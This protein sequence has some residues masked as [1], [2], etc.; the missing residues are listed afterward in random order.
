MSA[1]PEKTSIPDNAAPIAPVLKG[2]VALVTGASSGIGAG[3]AG[4]MAAAGA[5][6]ILVGRDPARLERILSKVSD[7]SSSC[8]AI[9]ADLSHPDG[10]ATVIDQAVALAGRI[11]CLVNNAGLFVYEPFRE[12]PEDQL[13]AQYLVNV[14]APYALTRA[15]VPVMPAGSS[16]VFVSSNLARVGMAG[17]AA[18]SATKG[19]VESM[20]RALAVELAPDIRVNSVAPGIIRTPM[21]WRLEDEAAAAS[22]IDLTPAGRLG[23]VD[24]VAAAVTFLSSPAAG[25]IFG[26]TLTVDGGWNAQ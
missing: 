4:H 6:V 3:V 15:A 20:A 8:H 16:V 9:V 10:C 2:R 13:D 11:D 14:R 24:D 1:T 21:T 12:T 26:S 19:A 5:H 17:T 22:V 23:R 25:Y 7:E 18:Y